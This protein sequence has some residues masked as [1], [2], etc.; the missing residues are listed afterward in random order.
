MGDPELRS[1]ETIL[2]RT[3]GVFVKSIAFEGYLTNKRIILI[4][5]V[6]NLLPQKEI[7]LV[8]IKDI[9]PGENAIRDQIITLSILAKNGETRQMILTFSRQTGGNRIKERN[10]WVKLLKENTSSSI[11]QVIRK[12]IPGAGPLLKKRNLWCRQGLR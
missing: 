4:D 12:V 5:R 7:P 8:T 3:P 1:D 10:E 2:L 6:K 11:D 9:E